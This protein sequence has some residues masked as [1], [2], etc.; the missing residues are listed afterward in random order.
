MSCEEARF[1]IDTESDDAALRAHLDGC[2]RCRAYAAEA[3][4]EAQRFRDFGAGIGPRRELWPPVARR[5]HAPRRHARL[6]AAA[7]A[8][9]IITAAVVLRHRPEAPIG[10]EAV[11][12]AER[13]YVAAFALLD[14]ETSARAVAIDAR[15]AADADA[16]I[17]RAR[18]AVVAAPDDARA[19]ARWR[20]ACDRK[21]EL[22]RNAVESRS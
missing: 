18:A 13:Q 15:A 1:L 7:A 4:A 19:V 20:A 14:R 11:R 3:E 8:I 2:E 16:A 6:A 22:L 9:V 10:N 12:N 17:A 21:V 5:I